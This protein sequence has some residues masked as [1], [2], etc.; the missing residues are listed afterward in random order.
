MATKPILVVDDDESF[1]EFICALLDGAG[2]ATVSARSGEDA[3][4][5]ARDAPP[6][7]V[8][9]DV[10]LPGISGYELGR[11]LKD[12]YG[13]TLPV[14]LVSGVR[15]ESFDRAAGLLT[16]ADDY[17]VKPIDPG[18]LLARVRC[19]L[20]RVQRTPAESVPLPRLTPREIEVLRLL[21][22]GLD[23]RTIAERLV[24]TPKTVATHIERVLGKLGV[25]N[26]A[27]A[28]AFAYRAGL[29]ESPHE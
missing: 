21:A 22:Q 20:E 2:Y 27:Q 25:R 23:Q 18:E 24:I 13:S 29:F 12:R 19:A 5:A 10:R 1:R 7:L 9:L 4:A 8:L 11:Q 6:A 26:R 14:L 28:V 17:L 16:G 3:L 15:T